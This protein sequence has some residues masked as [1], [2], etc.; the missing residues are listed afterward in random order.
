MKRSNRKI[1][2]QVEKT[3]MEPNPVTGATERKVYGKAYVFE[4][5]LSKSI[6]DKPDEISGINFYATE[7]S[8]GSSPIEG[9]DMAFITDREMDTI[10]AVVHSYLYGVDEK[11]AIVVLWDTNTVTAYHIVK[12]F[13]YENIVEDGRVLVFDTKEDAENYLGLIDPEAYGAKR[14]LVRKVIMLARNI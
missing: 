6:I 7:G 9:M 11:P 3:A 2:V 1:E 8:F 14:L 4:W 5:R 10:S 12:E 13:T